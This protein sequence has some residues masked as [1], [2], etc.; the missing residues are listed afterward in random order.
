MPDDVYQGNVCQFSALLPN[1]T[2][3]TNFSMIPGAGWTIAKGTALSVQ[4]NFKPNPFAAATIAIRY[5][6]VRRQGE[7][8]AEGLERQVLTYPSTYYRLLPILSRAFVFIELGRYTVCST[9]SSINPSTH[10]R[11]GQIKSLTQMQQRLASRD[12]SLLPEMHALL[13]GLKVFVTTHGIT[14]I[15]TARRSMGG[16]G[17][18]AF[19]GLGRLYVDYLPSV[20]CVLPFEW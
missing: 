9:S 16:H 19:A 7:L 18:S 11:D 3:S 12:T 15:E 6:T 1:K 20:T 2:N 14:D 4:Y 10:L 17:Y 5:T 13:C 8:D